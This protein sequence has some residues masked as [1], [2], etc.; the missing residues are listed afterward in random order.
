MGVSVAP[1]EDDLA[2]ILSFQMEELAKAS[3]SSASDDWELAKSLERPWIRGGDVS[4][5]GSFA[6]EE[7]PA[8]R[9]LQRVH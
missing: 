4:R 3:H 5:L 9:R 7:S 6:E 2:L 8:D 1:S